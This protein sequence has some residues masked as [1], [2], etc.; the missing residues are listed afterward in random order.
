MFSSTPNNND[1]NTASCLFNN[2]HVITSS[3]QDQDLIL[4][5]SLLN[6]PSPPFSLYTEEDSALFLQPYMD[7]SLPSTKI[8][9]MEPSKQLMETNGS[10]NSKKS[11][12]HR[13]KILTKQ[14][15]PRKRYSKKD[16]HSKINTAQGLRDRR[17]RLSL[18]IARKFFDLQDMLGFDKASKTVEWLLTQSKSAIKD[19]SIRFSKSCKLAGETASESS[20]TECN[21]IF[22]A[23]G[24]S[25]DASKDEDQ[26]EKPY[27]DSKGPKL[28]KTTGRS[29]A[30]TRRICCAT[31]ARESREKARAR[32][33][34][35]TK[36]K[37]LVRR[38][39]VNDGPKLFEFAEESM[40]SQLGHSSMKLSSIG[41]QA[42]VEE[43]KQSG[44]IAEHTSKYLSITTGNNYLQSKGM[45]QGN[46]I[47]DLEMFLKP[48]EAHSDT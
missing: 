10:T 17:M 33:K 29:Q 41:Y 37:M 36:E 15:V 45:L 47:R 46:Q 1:P 6:F 11:E 21:A 12:Q 23:I 13:G 26:R 35:R 38:L 40:T 28:R 44:A 3:K 32:A 8:D 25:M 39:N 48:W 16:R 31:L 30:S 4:P 19:L 43:L 18:D 20:L 42:I 2:D 5:F 14:L 7:Y 34:E 9:V 24:Q 22:G 27:G